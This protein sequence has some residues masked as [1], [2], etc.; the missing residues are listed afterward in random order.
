MLFV[1]ISGEVM[2]VIFQKDIHKYFA[3]WW[4]GLEV[5]EV[6]VLRDLVKY[7]CGSNNYVWK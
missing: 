4:V 7:L 6:S 3:V 1:G 5:V 2:D